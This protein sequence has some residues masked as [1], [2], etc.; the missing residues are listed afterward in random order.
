M[1]PPENQCMVSAYYPSERPLAAVSGISLGQL[2]RDHAIETVELLKMDC[3]GGEYSILE[4]AP[5][6]VLGSIRNI[7]FEYHQIEG[8]WAKLE[9]VN[10]RLRRE[11]YALQIHDGLVSLHDREESLA[12]GCGS[13]GAGYPSQ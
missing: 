7:V 1:P 2:L 4:S 12:Y 13:G 8:A 3:E 6:E 5:A 10:K 11:G 9:R